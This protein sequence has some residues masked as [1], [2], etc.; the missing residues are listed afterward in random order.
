MNFLTLTPE[1]LPQE[2][3]CCAIADRKCAAGT[4]AKKTWLAESYAQGWRFTRLD[5]RGKAFLEYGPAETAWLPLDAP[6]WMAMGCFWVSGQFKRKG[7]GKDLLETALAAARAQGRAGLVTVAGRK[8]MHFLSDGAWLKRQGFVQVDALE[9]G[10]V[11][12][13]RR[14]EGQAEAPL[15]RFADSARRGL[16]MAGPGITAVWSHRCPFTDHHVGTLLPALCARRGLPFTSIKLDSLAAAQAAP[17]PAT[18]FSLFRD[19]RF[20]TTDLSVCLESRFDRL[21]GAAG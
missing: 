12:L 19:G 10:F 20:V 5:A 9:T 13:A 2:H 1:T 3:I 21:L 17:S 11:L 8:K 7:H 15:P 6:G 14:A 16:A 18:V 4:A